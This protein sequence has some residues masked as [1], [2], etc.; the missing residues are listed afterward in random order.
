MSTQRV[1]FEK[2]ELSIKLEETKQ[3]IIDHVLA[4]SLKSEVGLK[5]QPSGSDDDRKSLLSINKQKGQ[6]ELYLY[7]FSEGDIDKQ[8][9]R[10]LIEE[11][12]AWSILRVLH[13]ALYSD[14]EFLP[15]ERNTLITFQFNSSEKLTT[16]E[17]AGKEENNNRPFSVPVS[18]YLHSAI[19]AYHI[20]IKHKTKRAKNAKNIPAINAYVQ[21]SQILEEQILGGKVDFS[22]TAPHRHGTSYSDQLG[23]LNN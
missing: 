8:L 7:T 9:P 15:T 13:Q 16:I 11:R 6:R 22:H 10:A 2:L 18:H 17:N 20:G 19:T 3:Y 1:S 4:S 12:L 14:V 23:A 21:L 5:R